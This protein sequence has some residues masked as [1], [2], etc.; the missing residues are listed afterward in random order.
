MRFATTILIIVSL[1]GC[2]HAE[3]KDALTPKICHY[4]EHV[5]ANWDA[6]TPAERKAELI[7]EDF[8]QV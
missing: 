2:F 8:V 1:T 6:Y 3:L 4:P 5:E 7:C